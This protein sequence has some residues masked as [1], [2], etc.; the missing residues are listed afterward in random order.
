MKKITFSVVLIAL[1]MLGPFFSLSSA[2]AANTTYG[3]YNGM[4][5]TLTT[6]QLG[7]GDYVIY[8]PESWN[9][10]FVIGCTGY[11]FFQDP[12]PEFL[13]DPHA[14][15]LVSEGYAFAAS[16]YIGGEREYA[17]K[18]GMIR[19]HQLT[20]YVVDKYDVT[21]KIFLFGISM[22]GQI[23][24]NLA[25]KYPDLY[26]GVLDV[27]GAKDAYGHY[28][29]AQLWTTKTVAELRVIFGF[30]ESVPDSVIEGLKI[31]FAIVLAD[32]IEA[33]GGTIEEKP[34][35]Y[36]RYDPVFHAD[37]QVP[38]I[39]L[40]GGID[41]IVPL[42]CHYSYQAAVTACGCSDLYSLYIVP[43]GGHADEPVQTQIPVKLLELFAWSDS[44]D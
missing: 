32:T 12:H 10:R 5:Y 41:L 43:I 33:Y 36:E 17:V 34:Q 14:K 31:F 20:Q 44:L 8:M 7:G 15:W 18:E 42:S 16:N 37:L 28:S 11:N 24:L 40:V 9:G 4:D 26:S 2:K 6:G 25:D 19:T 21:G 23:A 38:T 35:V 29:Y 22:G 13:F 1:F 27:C 3:T 39:S 30:P